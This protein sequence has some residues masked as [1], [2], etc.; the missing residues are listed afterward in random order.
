MQVRGCSRGSRSRG[1]LFA[2]MADTRGFDLSLDFVTVD[3]LHG[4]GAGGIGGSWYDELLGRGQ[5]GDGELDLLAA[6]GSWWSPGRCI[7]L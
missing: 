4:F 6:A 2:N 3:A 5:L 7:V 1:S